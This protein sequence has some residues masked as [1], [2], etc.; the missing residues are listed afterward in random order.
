MTK[1]ILALALAFCMVFSLLPLGAQAKELRDEVLQLHVDG[2]KAAALQ[3]DAEIELILGDLTADQLQEPG[4][5]SF[6]EIEPNDD[7]SSV[8][9]VENDYTIYGTLPAED[10]DC[11]ALDLEEDSRVTIVAVCTT[12]DLVMALYDEQAKEW[13]YE[14]VYLDYDEESGMHGMALDVELD[15]GVYGL[16]L[17]ENRDAE[18]E[19]EFYVQIKSLSHTHSYTAEVTAPTC[20]EAGYTTYT[21]SCG[22]SYKDDEVPALG[23]KEVADAG[24]HATCTEKGL[25]EGSHCEV[26]NAVIKAQEEIPALGHKEVTD[27]AVHATCT[28]KGLT[29]GS[30]C[31]V[32]NAVIKAQEEIPALGHKEVIDVEQVDPTCTESGTTA[33]SHCEVCN[34]VIKTQ[35]EIPALGH[36]E[37]ID[38]A[39]VDPTCTEPGHTAASHCER[40]GVSI[41]V[42][43]ELAPLGHSEVT[44][45]GIPAT[46]TESGKT[47]GK[48]CDRCGVITVAQEVVPALGHS[49]AADE[50]LLPTCT[51]TGL[52]GGTHCDRCGI[53][54]REAEVVPA[55]GHEEVTDEAVAPSCVESGLTEGSHCG[56]CGI[57]L[58][59]QEEVLPE[60][61]DY[62]NGV[63]VNCG[64]TPAEGAWN[65]GNGLYATLDA[66]TGTLT[67][68]G[69]G[70]M[71]DYSEEKEA[72]W[73]ESDAAIRKVVL[74]PGVR[75]IGSR[76]FADCANLAQV[77]IAPS[78]RVIGDEAFANCVKLDNVILPGDL[79]DLGSG[80]FSGCKSLRAITVPAGVDTISSSAFEGCIKLAEVTLQE[81]LVRVESSAFKGCSALTAIT[82]PSGV[83]YIYDEA[84]S[85]CTRLNE[86]TF[87]GDAP[88]TI[89]EDAF[90]DVVANAYYYCRN[91]TWTE[92]KQKNYG[93]KLTWGTFN[94]EEDASGKCGANL[95]WRYEAATDTLTITGNGAMYDY[96]GASETPWNQQELVIAKI[97]VEDGAATIGNYAFSNLP[98]L[99]E[100]ILPESVTRIGAVAFAVCENLT[101]INI[102][103]KVTDIGEF[104]FQQCAKLNHVKLPAGLTTL[105]MYV[106][107][108]C[109]SL[110]S[111]TIPSS[112]TTI[113]DYALAGCT[114]LKEVTIE[115]G[116]PLIGDCM[117][118]SSSALESIV[119][120]AS[121]KKIGTE[122]F[123]DTSLKE[124]SFLGNAPAFADSCFVDCV[125]TAYYPANNKTWTDNV[126]QNY[127]GTITWVVVGEV[128]P[129]DRISGKDRCDTAYAVADA[130]KEVLGVKKFSSIIIAGGENFA[131][132]LAGS[133][134]AN[135]KSAPILLFMKGYE[136]K[137]LAYITENLASGGT[138]YI[139]G[140]T[141][142]VSQ[143][144]ED[145]LKG[146]S[147]KRL[148]GSNRFETNLEILKEA[149][150]TGQEILISTGWN[151]ADCLSAS[152][153]GLP[154]LLVDTNGGNLTD[155]QV[156]FLKD[157]AKNTYT[158]IGGD[159]TVSA[160]LEAKIEQTIE[161]QV[162]RISGTTR[163]MTSAMV[164]ETYFDKPDYVLLAYSRNFPDGLCG[165][166]LAYAMNAPLL[167]INKGT[168]TYAA[169]YVKENGI[170]KGAVLGG[171]ATVSNES[172]KVVFGMK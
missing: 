135:R 55:L 18:A 164:A 79:T 71:Y 1:R 114:S 166:P 119:I 123:Y 91:T 122:A 33:A 105:E 144:M 89:S 136:E 155:G 41:K 14:S 25:T 32:C 40:C 61:H 156:A 142:S 99:Q 5:I 59:A 63:C 109:T 134:L 64:Q 78:V 143:S 168:E 133:Y 106:F 148:S 10:I 95:T 98:E 4:D 34:A 42:Q 101:T 50:E 103:S 16:A 160:E 81:G 52:A 82:F 47:D 67:V 43:Q 69:T 26:C 145:A 80:A 35:E 125:A 3:S 117:F 45:A 120:P 149:G 24:V 92:N 112:V 108:G 88:N 77:D 110:T 74:E 172:G 46:C 100:V 127:G 27:A 8:Y 157:H 15:A 124:I 146:F 29:E 21:C 68:S 96:A 137:N 93:G 70:D 163:E 169:E 30:H 158:V 49:E 126:M 118:V 147:V 97:V 167:L 66:Q 12:E 131:D 162:G 115:E 53:V 17:V 121:V 75:T 161:R 13:L 94:K 36:K 152:A 159:A 58:I 128:L 20:T 73:N 138:V 90:T 62:E 102:P 72:P 60:G 104:A 87:L 86:I 38:A 76:A 84:F 51:E 107:D 113:G 48:H 9:L 2:P 151:F 140:G 129:F 6:Q 37:V 111:I 85:G 28:E 171:T 165:G 54:I 31:E 11:F 39:Q 170:T 44:D 65:C 150:V 153:T 23:H 139:L 154:I 57:V 83:K 141:A 116:V 56:R 22:D 132:A 7:F 130:L 19:Y